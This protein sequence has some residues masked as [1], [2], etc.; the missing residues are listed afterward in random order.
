M[1]N[2]IFAI[3]AINDSI[4]STIFAKR[5]NIDNIASTISAIDVI[6]DSTTNKNICDYCYQ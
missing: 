5:D 3:D 2:K 1:N 4:I 6:N